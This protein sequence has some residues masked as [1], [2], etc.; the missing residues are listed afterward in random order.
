MTSLVNENDIQYLVYKT[1]SS[2]Q[3]IID[4]CGGFGMMIQKT[5]KFEHICDNESLEIIYRNLCQAID[6]LKVRNLRV[7][8]ILKVLSDK[9]QS[10]QFRNIRTKLIEYLEKL[11]TGVIYLQG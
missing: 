4:L 3:D 9:H 1:S 11:H 5:E 7:I 6:M 8:T 10:K 2:K